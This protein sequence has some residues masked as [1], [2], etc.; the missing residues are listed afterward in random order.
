MFETFYNYLVEKQV[1]VPKMYLE[2]TE[3]SEF[4]LSYDSMTAVNPW[5]CGEV[6][7]KYKGLLRFDI[8]FHS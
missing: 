1:K 8:K 7:G 6:A 4:H 5:Y 2:I 3:I